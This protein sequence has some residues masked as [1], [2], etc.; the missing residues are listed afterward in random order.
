[1]AEK[2]MSIENATQRIQ[3]GDQIVLSS[4]KQPPPMALLRQIVRQ[5]TRGIRAVGV[6]GGG[7]NIDFLIGAGA[8]DSIDTC[9]VSLGEFSR[10]GPNFARHVV[11]GRIRSLDNT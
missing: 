9:S 1:M 11:A 7:I 6:V 2:L 4:G 8:A 10:T 3:D 5:G